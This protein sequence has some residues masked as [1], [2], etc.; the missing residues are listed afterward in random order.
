M[1]QDLL[2]AVAED[3]NATRTE[4]KLLLLG[5]AGAGKST[6]FKQLSMM[7]TDGISKE[8]RYKMLKFLRKNLAESVLELY[9]YGLKAGV[10]KPVLSEEEMA[11][12]ASKE[13]LSDENVKALTACSEV[14]LKLRDECPTFL[15]V[16]KKLDDKRSEQESETRLE[17]YGQR[18]HMEF[19]WQNL[20]LI[21]A[22]GHE[23]SDEELLKIRRSTVG[24]QNLKFRVGF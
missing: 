10:C 13:E 7:Y 3:P 6:I 12:L 18:E 9:T 24:H 14:L 21:F 16:I 15:N 17:I 5:L 20:A 2:D 1:A 4:I 8:E 22:V 19:F 11:V 23:V